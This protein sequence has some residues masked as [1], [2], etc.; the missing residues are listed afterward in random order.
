MKLFNG[1]WN[2]KIIYEVNKTTSKLSDN[3]SNDLIKRGMEFVGS[4]IIYSYLQAIGI[5][6]VQVLDFFMYNG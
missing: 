4:T 5:V 1:F 6:Y 2:G 3:I